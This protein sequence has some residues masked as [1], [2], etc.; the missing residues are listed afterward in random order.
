MWWIKLD[1]VFV[2][3]LQ[4]TMQVIGTF[5]VTECYKNVIHHGKR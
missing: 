3:S 2:I 5:H 1:V 4:D